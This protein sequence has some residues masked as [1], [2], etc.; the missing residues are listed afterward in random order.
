MPIEQGAC[1][2]HLAAIVAMMMSRQFEC[3]PPTISGGQMMNMTIVDNSTDG[4]DN[5]PE[6][7][8][9]LLEVSETLYLVITL[10]LTIL[11]TYIY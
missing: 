7:T 8:P 11:R 10:Y 6:W 5:V 4:N 1:A 3:T 2:K 9:R